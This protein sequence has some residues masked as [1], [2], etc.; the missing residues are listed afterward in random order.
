M[1]SK[2]EPYLTTCDSPFGSGDIQDPKS[3]LIVVADVATIT[4]NRFAKF[5]YHKDAEDVWIDA[6]QSEVCH[7]VHIFTDHTTNLLL[8]GFCFQNDER[9]FQVL[10]KLKE[11]D[12]WTKSL[13]TV[14]DEFISSLGGQLLPEPKIS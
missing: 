11:N 8:I 6:M 1:P 10:G 2:I 13:R 12:E 14:F 3:R 5:D 4:F 7:V 9:Y